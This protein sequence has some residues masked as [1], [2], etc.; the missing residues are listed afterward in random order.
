[1]HARAHGLRHRRAA[2]PR[3]HAHHEAVARVEADGVALTAF[4]QG[5]AGVVIG[6][7]PRHVR[8]SGQQQRQSEHQHGGLLLHGRGHGRGAA[9]GSPEGEAQA[10]GRGPF[11]LLGDAR[12]VATLHAAAIHEQA[13]RLVVDGQDD[14]LVAGLEPQPLRP[15][16]AAHDG[17]G[18]Q[19]FLRLHSQPQVVEAVLVQRQVC[20]E[21]RARDE[22]V[23]AIRVVPL[24][25]W[26]GAHAHVGHQVLR[27]PQV[28]RGV[29]RAPGEEAPHFSAAFELLHAERLHPQ[30]QVE[31]EVMPPR[32]AEEGRHAEERVVALDAEVVTRRRQVERGHAQVQL[33]LQEAEPVQPLPPVGRCLHR[34]AEVG[35]HA[36]LHLAVMPQR[37]P[38][39]SEP[40]A[41]VQV[42]VELHHPPA[43]VAVPAGWGRRAGRLHSITLH[44]L[45]CFLIER[46]G[47][48]RHPR[49]QPVR[50]H[51][52][53]VQLPQRGHPAR[54]GG[55]VTLGPPL[56]GGNV[57]RRWQPQA[58]RGGVPRL[59]W[60]R[61]GG[62]LKDGGLVPWL[63]E[64]EGASQGHCGGEHDVS[65]A[66]IS[67]RPREA[68][69]AP[70]VSSAVPL[71]RSH[72][73]AG[74]AP[75]SCT[76]PCTAARSLAH[77]GGRWRWSTGGG[78]GDITPRPAEGGPPTARNDSRSFSP[79]RAKSNSS[80]SRLSPRPSS[81]RTSSRRSGRS[82]GWSCPSVCAS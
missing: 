22:G 7:A 52:L 45:R 4:V 44:P 41:P 9:R 38:C 40:D 3:V 24:E 37:R 1:M 78:R 8:G 56:A 69:P 81:A 64:Q 71:P 57:I 30:A 63:R 74:L 59:G 11:P 39:A 14:D 54:L 65:S 6:H 42:E 73:F 80:G 58:H 47:A 49:L 72:A 15:Q 17:R 25:G 76:S 43:L 46:D 53:G 12:D 75:L 51:A 62:R 55:V 66:A 50:L 28:H 10:R 26:T 13:Q 67:R 82:G 32:L 19:H 35:A 77:G 61:G 31:V 79:W 68:P 34:D 36:T 21:R 18:Q 33:R 5:H 2:E 20:F 16:R 60:K 27:M 23:E 70:G 29:E 48:G